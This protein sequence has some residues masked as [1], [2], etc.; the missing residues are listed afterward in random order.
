MPPGRSHPP[1]A[2]AGWGC[3]ATSPR[4]G[5]EPIAPIC[6]A[7]EVRAGGHA[8]IGRHRVGRHTMRGPAA[9]SGRRRKIEVEGRPAV[10]AGE[11]RLV[12]AEAARPLT[13][14]PAT[15]VL[16][17]SS[18]PGPR[19][20]P[21]GRIPAHTAPSR[22]GAPRVRARPPHGRKAHAR[23]A[24]GRK[25]RDRPA[26]ARRSGAPRARARPPHARPARTRGGLPGL[27]M[28]RGRTSRTRRGR[29]ISGSRSAAHIRAALTSCARDPGH[30]R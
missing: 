16:P 14:A 13:A 26:R 7:T 12:A 5:P 27:P 3:T 20:R 28:A 29:A 10:T 25:A 23:P 18:G 30:H 8:S 2:G 21:A 9:L 6:P 24:R 22:S 19:T 15:P 11:R 1:P 4:R 17:P